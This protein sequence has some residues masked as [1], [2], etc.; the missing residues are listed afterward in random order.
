M[1]I[2]MILLLSIIGLWFLHSII[3]MGYRWF[4]KGTTLGIRSLTSFA[5]QYFRNKERKGIEYLLKALLLLRDS[6]KHEELKLEPLNRII[7]AARCLLKFESNIPYRSLQT[8]ATE[9]K[10][11]PSVEQLP[12]AFSTFNID[13]K[14][15]WTDGFTMIDRTKRKITEWIIII[16]AVLSGLTFLPET[17]RDTL[18]EILQST[19]STENIQFITG[20]FLLVVIMYISSLIGTFYLSPL[21]A[22]EFK[23]SKAD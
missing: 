16:A 15:Q 5:L 19:G 11:F 21:E 10:L 8:L 3:G 2:W 6:L 1:F 7:K 14:V 22:K 17:A 9:L 4:C 18:L 13:S 12:K 23:L 20:F